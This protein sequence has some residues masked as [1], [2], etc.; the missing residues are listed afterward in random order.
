MINWR[1]EENLMSNDDPT[2]RVDEELPA[3]PSTQPTIETVL[4]RILELGTRLEQ[5]ID[6]SEEHVSTRID[7]LDQ[8]LNNLQQEVNG[9]QQGLNQLQQE[10]NKNFRGVDRRLDV[11]SVDINKLRADMHDLESSI[12]QLE[13]KPA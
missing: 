4:Q 9:L 8:G 13:A 1:K 3:T 2:R 12:G 6:Q 10:M 11:F 5:K 7:K